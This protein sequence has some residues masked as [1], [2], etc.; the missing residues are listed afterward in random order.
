MVISMKRTI[1]FLILIFA[2][3]VTISPKVYCLTNDYL[4]YVS[5]NNLV[6]D[7]Y[8]PTET[9]ELNNYVPCTVAKLV[10]DKQTGLAFIEM[11]NDMIKD[12]LLN[13]KVKSGYR[14][15]N[16]QTYI[17]NN[18]IL[19]YQNK[20]YSYSDSY[21]MAKTIIA[22]PAS[23]EHQLGLALDVTTDGTLE[24]TFADT[25][26]GK[27]LLENSYR[28]GFVLSFPEEK[29]DI[30]GII[31][32]PWHYRYVGKIHAKIMHENN[33]CLKEYIDY[34]QENDCYEYRENDNVI[35]VFYGEKNITGDIVETSNTNIKEN[36][37][38][39]QEKFD[40]L[41]Y[42][43]G[44]WAEDYILKFYE[45]GILSEDEYIYPDAYINRAQFVNL[46]AKRLQLE[47][48]QDYVEFTDVLEDNKYF[49]SIKLAN[50]MGIVSGDGGKFNPS[51]IVTRQEMFVMISRALKLDNITI[52]NYVDIPDISG[53]AFQD[54]QKLAYI[55]AINGYD[56]NTIRPLNKV[57]LAEAISFIVKCLQSNNK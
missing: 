33:W 16:T 23:S 54:V 17:F 48:I 4:I 18:R 32:E 40:S 42:V 39:T 38:V 1:F 13:L 20:G 57:T 37:F 53:W 36:M 7:D 27:W 25:A 14:S 35:R 46:A 11:Y 9:V 51:K 3:F 8:S 26:E 50:E 22:V 55:N 5:E 56:D 21:N 30:T 41:K 24:Q 52:I 47:K 10:V 12:G 2:L 29:Q 15:F 44:H 31:Y 43:Y 49:D 34:L 45:N 6:S 28:Y 19:K